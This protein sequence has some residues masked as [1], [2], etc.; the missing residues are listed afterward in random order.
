M[1]SAGFAIME[2]MNATIYNN[3]V[4]NVRYGVRISVGGA[5]NEIYDNTFDNCFDGE[6]RTRYRSLRTMFLQCLIMA[7]GHSVKEYISL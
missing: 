5:G 7:S 1:Q 3:V 2:S 4:E 6:F